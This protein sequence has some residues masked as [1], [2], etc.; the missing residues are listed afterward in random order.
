MGEQ[1]RELAQIEALLA[2]LAPRVGGLPSRGQA[3]GFWD[4]FVDARE[5]LARGPSCELQGATEGLPWLALALGRAA[6]AADEPRF[7][8]FV[9]VASPPRRSP[10]PLTRRLHDPEVA[11]SL[12]ARGFTVEMGR[13]EIHLTADLGALVGGGGAALASAFQDAMRLA[14]SVAAA[15]RYL[16]GYE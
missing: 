11:A 3:L 1:D 15:E 13:W 12:T 9:E 2:E 4:F 16:P 14:R 8:V 5:A 6:V 10:R 7:H